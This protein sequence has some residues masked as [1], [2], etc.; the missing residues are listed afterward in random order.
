[1]CGWLA[2]HLASRRLSFFVGVIAL[3]FSTILLCIGSTLSMWIAGQILGGL[4]SAI[5][6]TAGPGLLVDTVGKENVGKSMGYIALVMNLAYLLGPLLGGVVFDHCGYTSVFV[7]MFVII[8]IDIVLRMV[9]IEKKVSASWDQRP[10]SAHIAEKTDLKYWVSVYDANGAP[11]LSPSTEMTTLGRFSWAYSG[12]NAYAL[13]MYCSES[14]RVPPYDPLKYP[15][16]QDCELSSGKTSSRSR[17]PPIIRLLGSW[18]MLVALWATVVNG[19]VLCGFDAILPLFV[20]HAFG[21][22][23]TGAGLIF[24]TLT[25]PSFV[26]PVIGA[27]TDKHGARWL[28]ALGLIMS[29]PILVLLRLVRQDSIQ[30]ILLLCFLLVVLGVSMILIMTP[31]MAE[32]TYIVEQEEEKEPGVFGKGGAYAQVYGLYISSFGIGA[33]TGPI[34]AGFLDW[35]TV[36]LSFGVVSGLTALP[37]I[38]FTGGSLWQ[39]RRQAKA[40][41]VWPKI[42]EGHEQA[43]CRDRRQPSWGT[44]SSLGS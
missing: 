33:L 22:N 36:T 4:S 43:L 12:R 24:L 30:H 32:M 25:L 37:V 23:A 16:I 41:R 39:L 34:W 10:P 9:L 5:C 26:S 19:V 44:I 31:I 6:W 15:L 18:R 20:N 28:T 40:N 7:M 1:M 27:V 2:D 35:N 42:Y 11:S 13:S 38:L 29:F 3:L 21:W 14:L 17:L 8:L